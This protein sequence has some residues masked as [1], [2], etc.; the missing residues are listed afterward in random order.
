[1]DCLNTEMYKISEVQTTLSREQVVRQI[2]GRDIRGRTTPQP[3]N[4][5]H[6]INNITWP[7]PKTNHICADHYL[8]HIPL[9]L[10]LLSLRF[11]LSFLSQQLHSPGGLGV[12]VELEK[13]TQVLQWVLLQ[14]ASLD[15]RLCG[16]HNTLDLVGVNDSS[17]IWVTHDVAG[18]NVVLLQKRLLLLGAENSIKLLKSRLG[19][20][21]EPT[22]VTT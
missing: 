1:M 7:P 11:A 21:N 20:H 18:K 9:G 2:Y 8:W 6:W 14:S 5:T 19:P 3:W 10:Q 15:V 13:G 22:K 17:E 12:W 16:A 4:P